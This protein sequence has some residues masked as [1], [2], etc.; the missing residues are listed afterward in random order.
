MPYFIQRVSP[1]VTVLGIKQGPGW[2]GGRGTR[3]G[4]YSQEM[5]DEAGCDYDQR[6]GI[7]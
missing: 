3:D 4:P 1:K 6:K 2:V 5:S 7:G